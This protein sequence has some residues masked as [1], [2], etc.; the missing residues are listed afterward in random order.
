MVFYSGRTG[1]EESNVVIR[2]RLSKR[3][4]NRYNGETEVEAGPPEIR[5]DHDLIWSGRAQRHRVR[6]SGS[7]KP[8]VSNPFGKLTCRERVFL[9]LVIGKV[10]CERQ[11]I[12][13]IPWAEQLE[14]N[15]LAIRQ[16]PAL[17]I[18]AHLPVINTGISHGNFPK[19]IHKIAKRSTN[20]E[21]HE[22]GKFIT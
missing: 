2:M 7:S 6:V 8:S 21:R 19:L 18:V 16:Y 13:V 20:G 5:S 4:P 12:G 10:K 3:S 17:C 11:R 15:K 1:S 22:Q 14:R 9:D